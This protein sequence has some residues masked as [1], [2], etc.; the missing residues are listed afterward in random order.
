MRQSLGA[1]YHESG[2]TISQQGLDR[3]QKRSPARSGTE[4]QCE[5]CNVTSVSSTGV[6]NGGD[7][8][9]LRPSERR[10]SLHSNIYY[11]LLGGPGKR[12]AWTNSLSLRLSVQ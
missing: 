12:W 8:D 7:E 6:A 3:S 9:T 11:R 4:W 1:P 5:S 2:F 10:A